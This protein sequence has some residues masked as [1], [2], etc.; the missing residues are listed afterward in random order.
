MDVLTVFV[1]IVGLLF[2]WMIAGLIAIVCEIRWG[3][4]W[5]ICPSSMDEGRNKERERLV[6]RSIANNI[7]DDILGGPVMFLIMG[8]EFLI[9]V[10][11]KIIKF[12]IAHEMPVSLV[13][14]A[15]ISALIWAGIL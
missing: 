7:V 6:A 10:W 15:A 5:G 1:I 2:L 13:I 12:C 3:F 4:P 9:A 8:V 14:I 11:R